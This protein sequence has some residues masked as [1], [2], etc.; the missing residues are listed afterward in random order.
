MLRG[1][2]D[3]PTPHAGLARRA[4]RQGGAGQRGLPGRWHHVAPPTVACAL[5]TPATERA[6]LSPRIQPD[7]QAVTERQPGARL[8]TYAGEAFLP[9]YI[10]HQTIV[11]VIGYYVVAW[12]LAAVAKYLVI[13][14]SALAATLLVYDVAVR[15]TRAT[16]W[17]FGMRPAH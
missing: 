4:G 10:L 16:R 1:R 9:F 6:L 8:I 12:E 3:H 13:S 2:G 7:D 17:L 14:L 5:R 11:F 15:R